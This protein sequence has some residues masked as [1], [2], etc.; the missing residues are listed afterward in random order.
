MATM[1]KKFGLKVLVTFHLQY[2]SQHSHGVI[3]RMHLAHMVFP[4][5]GHSLLVYECQLCTFSI[6]F[7]H[8]PM[9][10]SSLSH[11]AQKA[12]CIRD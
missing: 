1:F 7:N 12:W 9:K 8:S 5:K 10:I 11:S 2:N 3:V 6:W 4:V